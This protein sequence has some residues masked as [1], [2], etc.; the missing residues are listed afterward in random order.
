MKFKGS[1]KDILA[2]TDED[3]NGMNADELK[4]VTKRLVD[5]SNKRIKRLEQTRSTYSRGRLATQSRAYQGLINR[6]TGEVKRFSVSDKAIGATGAVDR[7]GKL[8]QEFARAKRFLEAK[9]S[10]ITGTMEL[11][12]NLS[13]ELKFATNKAE[14][15]FWELYGQIAKNNKDLIGGANTEGYAITSNEFQRVLYDR[16]FQGKSPTKRN[17]RK[18]KSIVKDMTDYLNNLYENQQKAQKKQKKDESKSI[19]FKYEKIKIF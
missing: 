6:K 5:A 18:P 15:A 9:T 16:V 19:R 11:A 7:K 13:K 2:M 17:I 14:T 1:I 4:A 8:H 12:E 3:I 10:T